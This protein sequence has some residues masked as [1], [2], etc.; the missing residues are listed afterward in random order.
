MINSDQFQSDLPFWSGSRVGCSK[1]TNIEHLSDI[2]PEDYLS[3][4]LYQNH[5]AG[6]VLW[7]YAFEYIYVESA[8]IGYNNQTD[9]TY[10]VSADNP[11]VDLKAGILGYANRRDEAKTDSFMFWEAD[12]DGSFAPSVQSVNEFGLFDNTLTMPAVKGAKTNVTVSLLDVSS[13]SSSATG[14]QWKAVEV[15]A[16]KAAHISIQK[17]ANNVVSLG[18]GDVRLDITV[19]DGTAARNLVEDGTDVSLSFVDSLVVKEQRLFTENG[20]AY[21]VFTGGEFAKASSAIIVQTGDVSETTSLTIDPLNIVFSPDKTVLNKQEVVGITATVTKPDGSFVVGVPVSLSAGRGLF[22]EQE[23]ITDSEGKVHTTFTAGL[24]EVDDEWVAQ[25][26]YVAIERLAYRVETV[27]EQSLNAQD[28]MLLADEASAGVLDFDAYGVPISAAFQTE[29]TVNVRGKIGDTVTIGDMADPNMEPLLVL[30]MNQINSGGTGSQFNDDHGLNPGQIQDVSIVYDHPLGAGRSAQFKS[31]STLTIAA[32]S[33]LDFSDNRGFRLDIKPQ[34]NG[35]VVD[36]ASSALKLAYSTGKLIL[37][38]STTSGIETVEAPATLS[39]WHSVAAK[40]AGQ[41]LQLYVDGAVHTHTLVGTI[42]AESGEIVVGGLDAVMRGFR[43]YDYASQPLITFADGSAM[44]TLQAKAETLGVK[45]LGNLGRTVTN[46]QLKSMRVALITDTQRNYASLLTKV[47]YENVALKYLFTVSPQKPIAAILNPLSFVVPSAHAWSWD[48]VWDGVKTT[49]GVLIPYEDFIII[50]EQLVYLYNQD[51]ENFD[52]TALAFASIGAATIIPIAKPLKPLL[53]PLKKVV[54]GMKKFPGARHF[55]GAIGT[56]TK[57]GLS[58]KTD[59]LANLLPFLLIAIELYKD[60]EV[61][62]FL[63]SAIESEDDLWVWVEY[64]AEVVK[65]E[66]GLDSLAAYNGDYFDQEEQFAVNSLSFLVASAYAKSNKDVGDKLITRIKAVTKSIDVKDAKGFSKALRSVLKDPQLKAIAA[67]GTS[68]LRVFAAVGGNK[69]I[70]FSR[71]SKNWRVNRWLV[72]I[73]MIYLV[74]EAD[75]TRLNLSDDSQ[76]ESLVSNLF[77]KNKSNYNGAVFQIV[78]TAYFHARHQ[79]APTKMPKVVG[80]DV[81]RAANYLKNGEVS[82]KAYKRQVDI[83]LEYPDKTE[84]WVELKSYSNTTVSGS[85]KPKDKVFSG[86]NIY[87]EFFHDYRLNDA[88]I[89]GDPDYKNLILAVGQPPTETNAI[90]TWYYQDFDAPKG[91]DNK[92]TAPSER[93]L[94]TLRAK[95][96][97]KPTDVGIKDYEYNFKNT[98]PTVE[99]NCVAKAGTQV[100]LRNTRSYFTEILDIIGSDFALAIKNELAGIE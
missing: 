63:M 88:F 20:M 68:A 62:E 70:K 53:A 74:E 83:V 81:V 46:S 51:W 60:P 37:S 13:G 7:E 12:G 22:S 94:K 59:K 43:V 4:R 34:S 42:T 80:I 16:G 5:D 91:L 55:A 17:S 35:D 75:A 9:E 87:R 21:V 25:V 100:T 44:V 27:G 39:E 71:E 41:Q 38:V 93:R 8:T 2:T 56:A 36:Y 65:V 26:G 50:G 76:F 78:Q 90:F 67:S 79:A 10:Y 77:S 84:E 23:L 64:I 48:G 1:L 33:Q 19:T 28:T 40:V 99:K 32:D 97:R 29:A 92:A 73:S 49:V 6:N 3:I 30:Q 66:G 31:T 47:G 61:F 52:P 96:C 86:A 98:R 45:S 95:L 54:D 24:N 85:V 57:A 11:V 89:T 69:L 15:L 58:G 18:Q 14:A 82:G 72:L